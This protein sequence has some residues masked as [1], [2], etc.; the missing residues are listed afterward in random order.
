M[1]PAPPV[2]VKSTCPF[3]SHDPQIP[4][5]FPPNY[6]NS[7]Q[8]KER[9]GRAQNTR[10]TVS[11]DSQYSRFVQARKDP[12]RCFDT[13]NPLLPRRS[14]V[15]IEG[16]PSYALGRIHQYDT[17]TLKTCRFFPRLSRPVRRHPVR[18]LR[19]RDELPFQRIPFWV[20]TRSVQI[21]PFVTEH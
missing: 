20:R 10:K 2:V 12:S 4:H 1:T 8:E 17:L 6:S 16:G 18:V 15:G 14:Y 13:I 7:T 9:N 5:S 11:R 3:G 19:A 21:L